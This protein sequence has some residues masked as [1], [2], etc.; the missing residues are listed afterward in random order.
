MADTVGVKRTTILL[1]GA[2]IENLVGE[3]VI[4]SNKN[5]LDWQP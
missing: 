1:S 2:K 4:L 5:R 3:Y